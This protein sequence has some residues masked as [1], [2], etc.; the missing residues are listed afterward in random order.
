MTDVSSEP[1]LFMPQKA[2]H[3]TFEHPT[4]QL[5]GRAGRRCV[6]EDGERMLRR[7]IAAAP[8]AVAPRLLLM[9][10]L[11]KQNRGRE[12]E[13][14][15]LAMQTFYVTELSRCTAGTPAAV[16]ALEALQLSLDALRSL[17]RAASVARFLTDAAEALPALSVEM[18]QLT[19]SWQ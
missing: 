10:N 9:H 1:M 12:A 18:R 17:G 11:T 13:V 4:G 8:S 15:P 3:C 7:C 19:S 14:P 6:L 2:Q 5:H 16:Q